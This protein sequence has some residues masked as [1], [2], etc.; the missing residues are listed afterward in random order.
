MHPFRKRWLF[1][2]VAAILL[3]SLLHFTFELLW[4]H[5]KLC[6]WPLSVAGALNCARLGYTVRE[7]AV[8]L[9][10]S[11]TFAVLLI[12]FVFYFLLSGLG[13]E[14]LVSDILLYIAAVSSGFI[15]LERMV[16]S[17]AF[18]PVMPGLITLAVWAAFFILFTFLP[19]HLPLFMEMRGGFY[20][21]GG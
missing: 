7:W 3:G 19:P 5:M 11:V 10:V 13:F 12:P 6:F 8:P 16:R 9:A 17:N 14:S 20:G 21:I 1:P 18:Y 4:E 2:A 15:V